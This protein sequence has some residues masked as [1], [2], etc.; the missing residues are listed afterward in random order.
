[1]NE[2]ANS[3]EKKPEKRHTIRLRGPFVFAW[4]RNGT[5]QGSSRVQV[6][7]KISPDLVELPA[8]KPDDTLFLRRTFGK[9]TGLAPTQRVTL[10]FSNFEKAKRLLLNFETESAMSIEFQN[11]SLTVE[12][13]ERLLDSNRLEIEFDSLPAYAGDVR[14][15]IEG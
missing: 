3:P 8:I 7:C 12:I 15:V 14:L 9:P 13:S 1:M 11:G 2:H 4:K 5:Q 6:P 10:E